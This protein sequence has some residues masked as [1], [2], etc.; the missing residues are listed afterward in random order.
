MSGFK[1]SG[2]TSITD[3]GH[4]DWLTRR[5]SPEISI[6][7]DPAGNLTSRGQTTYSYD[8]FHEKM[9]KWGRLKK[10]GTGTHF[11]GL[12]P[13]FWGRSIRS[14]LASSRVTKRFEPQGRPVEV[15]LRRASIWCW[16]GSVASQ[17]DQFSIHS[18]A[19][20]ARAQRRR[21]ASPP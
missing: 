16:W 12:R 5:G 1:P 18:R 2:T 7:Y 15:F 21:R 19:P 20:V 17:S 3:E 11:P 8:G 9:K 6:A 4:C 13:R 14:R 10:M